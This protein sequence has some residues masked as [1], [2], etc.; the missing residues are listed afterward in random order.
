[1]IHLT[2]GQYTDKIL[3]D[4]ASETAPSKKR[5]TPADFGF[6][7]TNG[8]AAKAHFKQCV[9]LASDLRVS[10]GD[11]IPSADMAQIKEVY[12]SQHWRALL[13]GDDI[14]SAIPV[15]DRVRE[16]L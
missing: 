6:G 11:T 1:M 7:V 8:I 13:A 12:V 2:Q 14:G 10:F 3:C 9:V 16:I 4:F 15:I 5:P